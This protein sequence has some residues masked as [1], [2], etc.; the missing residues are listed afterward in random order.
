MP[1]QTQDNRGK[2]PLNAFLADFRSN[3]SDHEL[4]QKYELS[5]RGFVSLIKALLARNLINTDDL[6]KRREKAV[7]RDLAK[8]SKFLSGLSICRQCSHPS[9]DPFE[10]CPACGAAADDPHFDDEPEDAVS[11]SGNHFYVGADSEAEEVELIEEYEEID[12][13]PTREQPRAEQTKAPPPERTARKN[14]R[15]GQGGGEDKSAD[16]AKPSALGEIR[17]IISKFKKK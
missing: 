7:Q 5:A 3:L 10:T 1:D 4:R 12:E 15:S 8:E 2:V 14:A 6:A 13:P 9:P 17:S 16:K 11:T